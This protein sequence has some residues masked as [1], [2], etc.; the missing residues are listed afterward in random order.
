MTTPEPLTVDT[1]LSW[2][3]EPVGRT[4]DALK[5]LSADIESQADEAGRKIAGSTE[6]FDSDAGNAARTKGA[7]DRGDTF[8]TG[9]VLEKMSVLAASL[10]TTIGDAIEVI[11]DK[12]AD[13]EDSR[14]DF[15]VTPEGDVRPHKSNVDADGDARI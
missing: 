11:R 4:A 9:D 6:Y 5:T 8:T 3:I 14:W 7:A 1:V 13:A 2:N 12:K 10:K 15:F